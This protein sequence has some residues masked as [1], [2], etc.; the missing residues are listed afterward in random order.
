MN[1]KQ[2]RSALHLMIEMHKTERTKLE[3][4]KPNV[5]DG[6]SDGKRVR[7]VRHEQSEITLQTVID[8]LDKL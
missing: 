3:A 4:E 5:I 1:E 2:L 8:M 6:H 7:Y